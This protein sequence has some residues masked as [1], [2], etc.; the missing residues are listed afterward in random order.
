MVNVTGVK[1][2]N[3]GKVYY[4]DPSDVSGLELGMGVIVVLNIPKSRHRD[5]D[6]SAG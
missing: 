2:R 5:G 3:A 4:F 6:G 1:F